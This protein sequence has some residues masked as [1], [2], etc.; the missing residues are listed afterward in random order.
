M[1][2]TEAEIIA[3][4]KDEDAP[5]FERS[6]ARVM[7]DA[8]WNTLSSMIDQVY[9]KA[10]EKIDIKDISENGP[11]IKGFVIPTLP[12]DF[13]QLNKKSQ[14]NLRYN[15]S[16]TRLS[17]QPRNRYELLLHDLYNDT[18]FIDARKR[19]MSEVSK[20]DQGI[21]ILVG[22]PVGDNVHQVAKRYITELN[23][24]YK[25][26]EDVILKGLLDSKY[27]AAWNRKRSVGASINGK[28]I[29]ITIGPETRLE[30][31]RVIWGSSIE[32]LQD[33]LN[34]NRIKKSSFNDSSLDFLIYK[35]EL[36]GKSI[37]SMYDDYLDSRLSISFKGD[38]I[39]DYS[40]FRKQYRDTIK[41]LKKAL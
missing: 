10:K 6:I 13:I 4:E 22:Q 31:I 1:M 11:I 36:S 8:N 38:K 32:P 14:T 17:N 3:I 24:L 20:S 16:V 19:F 21:S 5:M 27:L 29:D 26:D 41:G 7:L 9:G 23:E 30:D 37:K 33:K 15:R 25:L 40:D 2:L 34:R 12:E 18:A 35:G 28:Y 39:P